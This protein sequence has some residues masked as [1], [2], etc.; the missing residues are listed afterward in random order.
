MSRQGL[1]TD[2]APRAARPD[3]KVQ[4][5]ISP[6]QSPEI[7]VGESPIVRVQA[8]RYARPRKIR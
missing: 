1:D 6:L 5:R 7:A 4:F 2:V 8:F 3:P